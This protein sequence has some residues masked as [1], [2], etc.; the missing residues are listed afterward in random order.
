MIFHQNEQSIMSAPAPPL[1][2]IVILAYGNREYVDACL[3]GVAGQTWPNFEV[4]FVDNASSDDSADVAR[5]AFARLGLK[6]QVLALKENLGCAG[7]NN[8]GWLNARGDYVLF[9]N[10]DTQMEPACV[11]EL[12][13]PLIQDKTIGITG[14]KMY[15]PGGRI[16][17]HAGGIVHPN[18]MTN[19]HGA[20]EE[21]RGQCDVVRD[22]DYVTGAG[23]AMRR[24]MLN[25]LGGLDE[26][27]FPAY[28]EE[29]DLCLR[30]RKAGYRVVYIPTAVLVHHESVSVGQGSSTLHRL[31]PRMRIR[32][33]LKNLTLRQLAGWAL[34]FEYRWMRS[35]PAARGYRW[36]Q[37]RHGWLENGAWAVR[38]LA[39]GRRR[40]LASPCGAADSIALQKKTQ[41][42]LRP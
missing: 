22:V 42:L 15:F 25:T 2:S 17:Q 37:V 32:Y 23:L 21:D 39:S 20:G 38:W 41:A 28:Y 3:E 29:V 13:L 27:Y 35:E 26:D 18:G 7:G 1:L 5:A 30:V 36:K 4:V 33:L 10:P 11:A 12:I 31:F 24:E 9:L 6:G 19:H 40:K 34:P 8:L 14:A 16:I